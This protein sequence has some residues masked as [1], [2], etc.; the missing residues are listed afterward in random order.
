[1]VMACR[2]LNGAGKIEAMR[3]KIILYEKVAS[4]TILQ[5]FFFLMPYETESVC[6]KDPA[7]L[8]Y[9]HPMGLHVATCFMYLQIV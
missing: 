6:I 9:V 2:A 4:W 7:I 5:P 3:I 8:W 1:M